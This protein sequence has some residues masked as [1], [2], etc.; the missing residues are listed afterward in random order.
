MAQT[1]LLKRAYMTAPLRFAVVGLGHFA[2]VAVLPALH[3]LRGAKI[4]ALVSGTPAKLTQLGRR[5]QVKR[6]CR[7]EDY[8]ELLASGD[9]D[10]VYVALPP[11]LHTDVTVR[12]AE[13]G[14]H[15]LCEKPMAPTEDDCRQMIVACARNRVKLM[16]AYRLHFQPG[17]LHVL[18]LI[19]RGQIGEPRLFNSVFSHQVQDDNVRVEPRPGAGPLF[20]IGTYCINA[21][22][23]VFQDEPVRVIGTRID[24]PTDERFRHVEEGVSATLRFAGD[25][26]AAFQVSFGA[27]DRSHYEVIGTEGV[28]EVEHAYSYTSSM[29]V[30]LVKDGK[31]RRRSFR[32]TDQIA[33]EVQHFLTCVRDGVDPEPSGLE[34]LA[35]VRIINAIHE[36][37][38]TGQA[39][40]LA[41]IERDRYPVP[42]QRIVRPPHG[43]PALVAV[44]P[45]VIR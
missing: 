32:K 8:D 27:A 21:A 31:R 30:T 10:A 25:R 11:D 40:E 34:G 20:D 39:V 6:L 16:I 1:L 26:E 15:V 22:R 28:I 17:N 2:Q 37:A 13:R 41:P 33:A 9:V 29:A 3:K 43:Q 44:E 45:D 4:A 18:D 5:Y 12:A 36:A 24:N 19:R 23:Y 42:E 7:Y 38:R 35:D 14:I